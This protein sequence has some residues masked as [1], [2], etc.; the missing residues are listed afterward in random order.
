MVPERDR[1]YPHEGYLIGKTRKGTE[2]Y[3]KEYLRVSI[4]KDS[5]IQGFKDSSVYSLKIP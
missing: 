2:E 5:R 3:Y 1:K 4:V